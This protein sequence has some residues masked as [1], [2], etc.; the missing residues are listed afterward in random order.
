MEQCMKLSSLFKIS[1]KKCLRKY[2]M[3]NK[4]LENNARIVTCKINLLHFPSLICS[5]HPTEAA[6]WQFSMI[7]LR[8]DGN[9]E[10]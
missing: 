6:R 7:L 9:C 2:I 5:G 10:F 4:I 1:G 3:L 8:S